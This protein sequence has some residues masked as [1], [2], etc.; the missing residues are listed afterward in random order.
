MS[1]CASVTVG[2]PTPMGLLGN[3]Y[4]Y[5]NEVHN[6]LNI[7]SLMPLKKNVTAFNWEND[8]YKRNSFVLVS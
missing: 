2:L 7:I 3:S 1:N 8:T 6:A 5:V 4:S